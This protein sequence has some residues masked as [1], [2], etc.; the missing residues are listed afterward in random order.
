MNLEKQLQPLFPNRKLHLVKTNKGL[1]NSNYLLTVDHEMFMVRVRRADSKQIIH[2]EDEQKALTIIQGTKLD[3]TEYYFDPAQGIRITRY[4]GDAREYQEC[5]A[6]DKLERVAD[7]MRQLH[8]LKKT[9][10]SNFDPFQRLK[11]YQRS[12]KQPF[13][14]LPEV[15]NTIALAQA[16]YQPSTLCHNDWVSGN[17]LFSGER[18]YLIDYEY[19]ADNDPLFDVM[20]FITE[21]NITED[22]SRERFYRHYFNSQNIPYDKLAIWEDFHNLLWCSWAM[23]MYESR[24]EDIYHTIAK[25]KYQAYL[26]KRNH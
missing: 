10:G 5:N 19:A 4:L 18:T 20:S 3:V 12:I 17:I 25:A 11:Q 13:L 7:L 1:T 9:I 16:I 14:T 15:E 24:N 21:N 23:M 8:Q 26:R 2:A 6:L 22:D